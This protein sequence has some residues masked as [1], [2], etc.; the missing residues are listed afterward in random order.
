MD[1]P[2]SV[3]RQAS[4]SRILLELCSIELFLLPILEGLCLDKN[5]T[6]VVEGGGGI[7]VVEG[8]GVIRVGVLISP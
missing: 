6:D 2:W 7:A 3:A 8:T 1:A 4:R 5:D